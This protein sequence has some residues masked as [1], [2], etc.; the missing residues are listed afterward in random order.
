VAVRAMPRGRGGARR[1][2]GPVGAGALQVDDH[3][4]RADDPGHPARPGGDVRHLQPHAADREGVPA[5]DQDRV[6]GQRDLKALYPD[7]LWAN[8]KKDSP[9]WSEDDGIVVKRKGNPKES[10][11]EA[12][13]L[14]DGMP[15]SKHFRKRVYDDV[16]TKD[17]VNT[18]EMIEKTTGSLELS[19][20]L[21]TEDGVRSASSARATT[22][23]TPTARDRARHGEGAATTAR[24]N[25]ATSRAA[26]AVSA[27]VDGEEAPRHGHLHIRVPDPAEPRGD[28]THGFKRE[29]LEYWTPDDGRGLNKYLLRDPANSKKK[30]RRLHDRL[31]GRAGR[32]TRTSTCSRCTAIG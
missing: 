20:A 5:A 4:L 13:G 1:A 32:R 3:H 11:V 17:S 6:R 27:G 26:G 29:W 22:S 19:Y 30:E 25:A 15:T 28:A 9:K 2:P 18:P 31:G 10:T 14:V 24:G 12:W 7:V 21:G 23:T 8:P 16:V